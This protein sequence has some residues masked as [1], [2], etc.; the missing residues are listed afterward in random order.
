MQLNAVLR[1]YNILV[2]VFQGINYFKSLSNYID[3]SIY[4]M[5][6]STAYI[7]NAKIV[8]GIFSMLILMAYINLLLHME[9]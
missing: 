5:L 7:Q 4:T 3:I 2:I 1:Y 9:R 8:H 6:V